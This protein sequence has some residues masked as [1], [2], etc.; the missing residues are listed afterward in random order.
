MGRFITM[1]FLF[2]PVLSTGC[3]D[4][5]RTAKTNPC[6]HESCKVQVPSCFGDKCKSPDQ[7]SCPDGQA[8]VP[9]R[10]KCEG[11]SKFN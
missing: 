2:L 9:E 10:A 6:A 7:P 11:L 3:R 8:W 5:S 1:L 4:L